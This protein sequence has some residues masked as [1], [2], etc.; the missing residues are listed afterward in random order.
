V[1]KF[2]NV[3]DF[4][5]FEAQNMRLQNLAG[6]PGAPVVGLEYFD[7]VLGHAYVWNGSGW[8]QASGGGGSGT[9]SSVALAAPSWLSVTGSPVTSAG[10]ITLTAATGQAAGQVLATP[11]GGGAVALRTLDHTYIGDFDTQVRTSRLDQMAAPTAAVPLNSQKITNLATPTTGTD[12]ANKTYVDTV[13]QGLSQKPTAQVATTGALPANTYANGTSGVGATLTANANGA[14]TVDGYAV[15]AGDRVLVK[16]EAVGANNGLYCLDSETEILT[17]DGWKHHSKLNPGEL[18]LTY[19]LDAKHT[20]WQPLTA[21]HCFDVTDTPMVRMT[22]KGHDSLSTP[23][24]RW[25]TRNVASDIEK[26]TFTR[27]LSTKTAIWKCAPCGSLPQQPEIDDALVELV[28]WFFTEGTIR[29]YG[30]KADGSC[31]LSSC[32]RIVQSAEANPQYVERIR[33]CLEEVFGPTSG[34]RPAGGYRPCVPA[35]HE[36]TANQWLVSFDLNVPAGKTLCDIAPGRVVDVRFLAKLTHAQLQLFIDT[37]IRADGHNR[38]DTGQITI[39]QKDRRRL[40][41]LQYACT[42]L[43]ISTTLLGPA[44]DGMY[45]LGINKHTWTIP[46][47]SQFTYSGQVWCPETPDGTWVARRNG[48]VYITGNTVTQPGSGAGPY[49]FTRDPEMDTAAEFAGAFIPVED[50]G[51]VNANSLWL[52]TNTAAP[53]VGTTAIV[54]TQ[55]NKG[56]DLV[57]GTGIAI[58][59]N[60][61]AISATYAGQAS[62]VTVGTLTTGVWQGTAVAVGF[63]GTGATTAPGARTNLGAKGSYTATIGDG[64]ATS[65]AIAQSTHG[66]AVNG[67]ILVATYDATSGD[68]VYPNE[69]VNN[70]N[71]TVTIAFGTAPAAN[72]YRVV[73]IG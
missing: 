68:R 39:G 42:L 37:A 7:T 34:P 64:V 22:S 57:A 5:K 24:H 11:T 73:L 30:I 54:F 20:R 71:G 18:V 51:A 4:S 62:I 44:A 14:L 43:G 45:T 48:T 49:I 17:K 60:S 63:G 12:A 9:V 52:C 32:V 46:H 36:R 23:D 19:S 38:Q 6:A 28:A 2:A 56:T 70:S 47:R 41:P 1:P 31:T 25:V 33:S 58:T 50:A 55:L 61:V 69:N 66:L 21:V 35:W 67:Q 16:D 3:V 40:D 13:A 65:F 8:E 15:A 26:I 59:G 29:K 53:V 10:T 72:A 27:D